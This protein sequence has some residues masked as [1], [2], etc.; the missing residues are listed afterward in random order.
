VRER[1]PDLDGTDFLRAVP[2]TDAASRRSIGALPRR[3]GW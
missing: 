3:L 2:F 1:R